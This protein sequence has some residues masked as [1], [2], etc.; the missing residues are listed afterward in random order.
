MRRNRL[1]RLEQNGVRGRRTHTMSASGSA[2]LDSR[3]RYRTSS[4]PQKWTVLAIASSRNQAQIGTPIVLVRTNQRRTTHTS[5]SRRHDSP[6]RRE[7]APRSPRETGDPRGATPQHLTRSAQATVPHTPAERVPSVRPDHKY[8]SGRI[9]AVPH[10]SASAG[11][12]SD[13]TQSPPLPPEYE[14]LVQVEPVSSSMS[15]GLPS[16]VDGGMSLR[17]VAFPSLLSRA[18]RD[19]MPLAP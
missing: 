3:N 19:E 6:S 5:L 10:T 15:C 11:Q 18:I 14:D 4:A 13:P 7:N 16:R 9:L 17:A 1:G 2:E 8:R 12:R